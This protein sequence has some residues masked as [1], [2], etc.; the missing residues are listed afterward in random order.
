MLRPVT[1]ILAAWQAGHRPSSPPTVPIAEA[2]GCVLAADLAALDAVP[3]HMTALRYGYAVAS[4]DL[5]GV[6]AYAP[7][8]R[9]EAPAL[10]RAGDPLPVGT[11]AVLPPDAVVRS[12]AAVEIVGEVAPGENVRWPGGELGAGDV[13]RR[14]GQVVR[15]IDAAL[16]LAAGIGQAAVQPFGVILAS[17]RENA[18][19]LEALAAHFRS[20][21][22]AGVMAVDP[23]D[24]EDLKAKLSLSSADMI[25]VAAHPTSAL[26][27]LLNPSGA[28]EGVALGGAETALFGSGPMPLVLAAPRLDALVPLL[29]CLVEPYAA[30]QTGRAPRRIWRRAR[31][32][33]K[34]AS[35]V[36]LTELVLLRE[37]KGGLEPLCAGSIT[38]SALAAAEGYLVVPP[39]SEGC[40]D[41]AE[42]EAYE[43]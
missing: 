27:G 4:S 5:V 25:L 30:S 22:Q 31:L 1:A 34:I 38:L 19:M 20:G 36:G 7:L 23:D 14:A 33:R 12:P 6:S 16:A 13:L 41:G 3:T 35:R 15:P 11:D 40:P 17:E 9:T 24:A 21:M 37:T 43:L 29:C 18:P 2:V 42:V 39:E 32:A 8:L 26:I 28:P 10:V